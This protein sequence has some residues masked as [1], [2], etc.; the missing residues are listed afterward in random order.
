MREN[1]PPSYSNTSSTHWHSPRTTRPGNTHTRKVYHT[2]LVFALVVVSDHFVCVCVSLSL[3]LAHSK[4]QSVLLEESRRRLEGQREELVSR[5]QSLLRS[6]WTEA[7]RLLSTQVHILTLKQCFYTDHL[8]HLLLTEI[9]TCTFAF[10]LCKCWFCVACQKL[11]LWD[12]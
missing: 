12:S 9:L 11:Y 3:R 2:R 7:L 5:L 8:C 6:H 1:F 10:C 4:Q